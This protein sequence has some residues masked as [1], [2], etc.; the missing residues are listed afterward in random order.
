MR[1][2][3]HQ[4][5]TH[6]L[7]LRAFQRHT[8]RAAR[9]NL[10]MHPAACMGIDHKGNLDTCTVRHKCILSRDRTCLS[11]QQLACTGSALARSCK[12]PGTLTPS[13]RT[14][15]HI[16]GARSPHQVGTNQLSAAHAQQAHAQAHLAKNPDHTLL[17]TT[18]ATTRG[19][20]VRRF[21]PRTDDSLSASA[22]TSRSTGS[23][24]PPLGRDDRQGARKRCPVIAPCK[25]PAATPIHK[26]TYM[27]F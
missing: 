15:I 13:Q 18:M 19:S 9:R 10:T 1:Q 12:Q 6:V 21:F 20:P 27:D 25:V 5:S 14:Q 22:S 26:I 11:A 17:L 16:R 2:H 23:S 24:I 8:G 3:N 4:P 7:Y